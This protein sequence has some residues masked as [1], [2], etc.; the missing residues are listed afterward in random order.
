MHYE[1]TRLST[2]KLCG[3]S[4]ECCAVRSACV[5]LLRRKWPSCILKSEHQL[6]QVYRNLAGRFRGF[7]HRVV[8]SCTYPFAGMSERRWHKNPRRLRS[9]KAAE[10]FD[11]AMLGD[12]SSK[13]LIWT[14]AKVSFVPDSTELLNTAPDRFIPRPNEL[15]VAAARMKGAGVK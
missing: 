3:S 4:R 12:P 1:C 11:W 14:E 8:A 15:S 2:S 13:N 6:S 10:H 9:C 5:T 7:N